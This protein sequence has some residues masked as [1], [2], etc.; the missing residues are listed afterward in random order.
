MNLEMSAFDLLGWFGLV[1]VLAGLFLLKRHSSGMEGLWLLLAALFGTVIAVLWHNDFRNAL[2]VFSMIVLGVALAPWFSGRRRGVL[3]GIALIN[4]SLGLTI[5]LLG[6]VGLAET[7]TAVHGW[8]IRLTS[9]VGLF[10]GVWTFSSGLMVWLRLTDYLPESVPTATQ[11][12]VQRVVLAVTIALGL[13]AVIWPAYATLPLVLMLLLTLELGALSALGVR[14][15][16]L[17]A[18]MARHVGFVGV[19]MALLGYVQQSALLIS[20]GLLAFAGAWIFQKGIV[21]FRSDVRHV[22]ASSS[23]LRES[24]AARGEESPA[25]EEQ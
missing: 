17:A 12:N 7:G 21:I 9:V 24:T 10:L 8:D 6:L 11:R 15:E 14:R 4:A 13:A 3:C 23:R 1:A 5:A 16:G 19:A 2:L 25:A 20:L 18:V 22:T